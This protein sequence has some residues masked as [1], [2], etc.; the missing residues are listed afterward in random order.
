MRKYALF[1]AALVF[2]VSIV[3]TFPS[4]VS[5]G[6]RI[7]FPS[8]RHVA[9]ESIE[10][11]RLW[12]PNV[13]RHRIGKDIIGQ[14]G[15]GRSWESHPHIHKSLPQVLLI[16]DSI[17]EGYYKDVAEDL[18]GRAYVG[19]FAS[20][21]CVGDPMLPEEIRVI[22][23]NYK[24]DVIHFNNGMHGAGYSEK[25]YAKYFPQ[26]L[27]TIISNSHGAKL[28]WATTTPERMGQDFAR[29]TPFNKRI[30]ARNKIADA[31]CRKAGIPID[32][33]YAVLRHHPEYYSQRG[34]GVHENTPG[35]K[36]EARSVA[37]SILR[38]L[39]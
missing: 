8:G 6:Q 23:T 5:R 19:Y 31:L 26:Y 14:Y 9:R 17:T 36:A 37:N 32:N 33:L 2:L 3:V 12:L 39:Q 11:A 20:S 24:F 28:I 22:L 29:F 18:K 10:W 4:V 30:E 25:E 21:L 13:V 16:G 27:H 1:P 15:L 38:A 35:Q 34:G 7:V